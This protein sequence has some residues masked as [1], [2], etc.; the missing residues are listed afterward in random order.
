MGS[1]SFRPLESGRASFS[2]RTQI[3][4]S[5]RWIATVIRMVT[6]PISAVMA[7][8]VSLISV[9][10][11]ASRPSPSGA[12]HGFMVEAIRHLLQ[13]N[14]WRQRRFA[15]IKKRVGGFSDDELRQLLERS[16]ALRF[17]SADGDELSRTG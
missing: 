11:A 13:H 1:R 4:G 6:A 10:G 7:L 2:G 14:D 16:G 8:V 5:N 12:A 9:F 17:E 3:Q 15:A